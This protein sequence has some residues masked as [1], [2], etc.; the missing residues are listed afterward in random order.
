MRH[1]ID[2][3]IEAGETRRI[4]DFGEVGLLDVIVKSGIAEAIKSLPEG[5]KGNWKAVA[6]TI[7]NN[8]R[9]KI[10]K[11]HL[12]DPAFYDKMSALLKEILA[13]LKAARISYEEF[14]K[15]V[16][17]QLITPLQAG[18]SDNSPEALDTP[19]KRALYSNLQTPSAASDGD[20]D[21]GRTAFGI[22]DPVLALALRLDEA[23][24]KCRPNAW[25]G[26]HSKEQVIKGALFNELKDKPEVERLF[27]IIMAQHEY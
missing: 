14:L 22:G 17:S 7:A 15:R 1:L 4:S 27:L 5:I 12:N 10:I 8:V 24:K 18:K 25:R 26:V 23:I 20:I 21:E 3:Y 6:E 13:D 9:S 11:D 2:T 19:G 16:A